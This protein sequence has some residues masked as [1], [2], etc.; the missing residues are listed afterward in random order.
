MNNLGL[1]KINVN[2]EIYFSIHTDT[3]L[4][5]RNKTN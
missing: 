1:Y 4:L 3:L 5:L 2:K